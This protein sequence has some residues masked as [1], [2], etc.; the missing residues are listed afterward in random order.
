MFSDEKGYVDVGDGSANGLKYTE[1]PF[2]G[3]DSNRVV[4]VFEVRDE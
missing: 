1:K 2:G 4:E 3:I